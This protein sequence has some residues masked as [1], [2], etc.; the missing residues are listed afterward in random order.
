MHEETR[1][2]QCNF[3]SESQRYHTK[4]RTNVGPV[5]CTYSFPPLFFFKPFVVLKI[6]KN[7]SNNQ[8]P[9]VFLYTQLI[10]Y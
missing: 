3:K 5:T 9:Y 6:K 1:A 4:Q 2:L 8:T 7:M 10:F